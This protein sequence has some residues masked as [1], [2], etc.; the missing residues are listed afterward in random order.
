[1]EEL[2]A[3]E[4]ATLKVQSGELKEMAT[5]IKTFLK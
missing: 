5:Q 3:L 4:R 2:T 1:L